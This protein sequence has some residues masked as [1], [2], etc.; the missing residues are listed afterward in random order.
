MS[1]SPRIH[2][3]AL[4]L[5]LLS[6]HL[7]TFPVSIFHFQQ[8][9]RY[10]PPVVLPVPNTHCH[11]HQQYLQSPLLLRKCFTYSV[12]FE[13]HCP[14]NFAFIPVL[15]GIWILTLLLAYWSLCFS[16]F[17][18]GIITPVIRGMLWALNNNMYIQMLV[19]LSQLHFFLEGRI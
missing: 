1:D 6:W 10:C 15:T 7:S 5:F 16:I 4:A 14:P 9:A 18:K 11:Y 3:W 12:S 8:L 17:K 19:S 13:L 2:P